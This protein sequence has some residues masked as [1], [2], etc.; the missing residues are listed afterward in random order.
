MQCGGDV[1]AGLGQLVE[2]LHGFVAIKDLQLDIV[3]FQ[4]LAGFVGH[5]H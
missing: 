2:F 4:N 5:F 1:Y 3:F